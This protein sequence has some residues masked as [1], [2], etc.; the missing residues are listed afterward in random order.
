MNVRISTPGRFVKVQ[1]AGPCTSRVSDLAGLEQS[2]RI[3][4]IPLFLPT[5]CDVHTSENQDGGHLFTI[6]HT[7][8]IIYNQCLLPAL[9]DLVLGFV[10]VKH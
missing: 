1:F 6:A 8:L 4:S 2:L 9:R 7:L 5:S 3:C 10:V